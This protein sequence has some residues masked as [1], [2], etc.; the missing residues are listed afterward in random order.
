MEEQV[1]LGE[2]PGEQHPVPLLVGD[3][4]DEAVDPE[5]LDA[6]AERPRPGRAGAAAQI[7][8]CLAGRRRRAA[9]RRASAASAASAPSS[10]A[11]RARD[12]RPLEVAAE[13]RREGRP[14]IGSS[15]RRAL[16]GPGVGGGR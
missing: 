12:D 10:A 5:R 13:L 2:E 7:P 16:L 6:A 3:L 1:V 14:P 15:P 4:L 8:V 9:P 11:S